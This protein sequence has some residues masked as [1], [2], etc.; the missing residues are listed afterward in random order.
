M[1]QLVEH[2][3]SRHLVVVGLSPIQSSSSAHGYYLAL[4]SCSHRASCNKTE[5]GMDYLPFLHTRLTRP[6]V[7]EVL[8]SS[9]NVLCVKYCLELGVDLQYNIFLDL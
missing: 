1:A 3:S 8:H 6:L 7:S 2:C 9:Q 5:F 4:L